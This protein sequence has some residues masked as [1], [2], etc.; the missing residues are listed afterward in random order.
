M[1]E[2]TNNAEL[3]ERFGNIHPDTM[4]ELQSMLRLYDLDAQELFFK[5]ES[6]SMKMRP[7]DTTLTPDSVVA[8]KKD[9]QEQLEKEARGKA[10]MQQTPAVKRTVRPPAGAADSFALLDSML[11]TTPAR[12]TPMKRKLPPTHETP[13]GS[14]IQFDNPSS[15]SPLKTPRKPASAFSLASFEAV[16]PFS[17]RTNAGETIEVLNPH[18]QRPELPLPDASFDSRISFIFRMD[19]K[20]FSYRTMYQK[21]TEA[22]E[23][24][25]ERIDEFAMAIQEHY[26]LPDDAFGDPSVASPSETI[27]V[28]RI[29]SDSPEGKFNPSSV[30]LESSR[31]AGGGIR[32]PLKLDKVS[33]FAFFPGQ[34]VAVKGVNASGSYFQVHEILEPPKLPPAAT[35]AGELAATGERLEAGPVTVFI[36]SGPYTTQDNLEFEALDELCAKAAEQQPDAVI[37]TG[38]FIDSDHPLVKTGDFDLDEID[39]MND[40]TIE[41]LFRQKIS[42]RISRIKNSMV[43]MIPSVRDAVSKHCAFPQKGLERKPLGLADNVKC[44]PN[45]SM[46]S[47]NEIVFAVSTNDILFHLQREEITRNP[48]ITNP[49][50]RLSSHLLTQR[51]FYPL[52]PPPPRDALP[53]GLNAV[54]AALDV[55]HLRLADLVNVTPDVLVLPSIL[56]SFAKVIDSVV[57]VNPGNAAKPRGPGTWVEMTVRPKEVDEGAMVEEVAHEVWER[58]RVEVRRI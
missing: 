39:G 10:K 15:P 40:G 3:I 18:I 20:S 2:P 54:G 5:W 14:R 13:R 58:A 7:E 4:I 12:G 27:A 37:L 56:G 9:V 52:F 29:V 44:L 35:S 32:T 45:P 1:D 30:C 51:S 55:P 21:L 25:D 8:F 43:L 33:S 53:A 26:S 48:L 22:A 36:A 42:R 57:V 28:G 41:D 31:M 6:Y 19:H 23:V 24:L 50:A 38:P 34:I 49:P 17:K 16:T 47:I 11:P 46:F